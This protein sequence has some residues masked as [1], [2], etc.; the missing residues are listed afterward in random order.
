LL[1]TGKTLDTFCK[2]QK[3]IYLMHTNIFKKRDAV[4]AAGAGEADLG[5][6]QTPLSESCRPGGPFRPAQCDRSPTG[7]QPVKSPQVSRQ[8][9]RR[10]CGQVVGERRDSMA[11]ERAEDSGQTAAQA[12]T[13]GA[14]GEGGSDDGGSQSVGIGQRFAD[15]TPIGIPPKLYRIG[16]I[17]EHS[18]LSRQTIHN[19]TTMGLLIEARRTDG[20]HRLYDEAVFERLSGIIA[21]KAQHKSLAYIREYYAKSDAG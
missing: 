6:L 2:I 21:L 12:S 19:Y 8:V 14:G 13:A 15:P 1:L 17:V 9:P 5:G 11:S 18:G 16:E 10:V 3:Y 7:D 4:D 20:G